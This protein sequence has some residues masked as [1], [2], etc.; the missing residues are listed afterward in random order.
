MLVLIGRGSGS[1]V[2]HVHPDVVPARTGHA[3]RAAQRPLC[4]DFCSDSVAGR[5]SET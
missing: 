3:L 5:L 1:E 4:S 2:G